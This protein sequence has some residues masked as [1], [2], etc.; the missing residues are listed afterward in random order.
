[1]NHREKRLYL[2][3]ALIDENPEYEEIQIPENPA[4]QQLLLRALMNVRPA[5]KISGDFQRIQ[6]AYLKED[7]LAKGVV[8][9]D[10]FPVGISIWQGD[11]T[12]LGTDVIVNAANSGM[13]GCYVPNHACI[14]NAIHTFAGIELRNQCAEIMEKQGHPEG[15]GLAKITP[16]YNLPSHYVIHTVGPIVEGMQPTDLEMQQV[17]SSYRNALELAADKQ[18][19]SIAFPCISTGLFHFPN[20]LAGQIAVDE[21][22]KF[23]QEKTSIKK[24]IFNV[25][26]DQDKA[27]YQKLLGPSQTS[28]A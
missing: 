7:A 8:V 14:D 21:V 13:T 19:T 15:T 6:D 26:K 3:K 23:L 22:K 28:L 1:M 2:I 9:D 12:R 24:V 10:E 4:Q 11:I 27:I 18:L 20:F 16:A 25:F 17:R 5:K